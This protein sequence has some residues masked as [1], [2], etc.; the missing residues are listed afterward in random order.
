MK[1]ELLDDLN[2]APKPK[3]TKPNKKVMIVG[4]LMSFNLFA[5]QI[6]TER[7]S[8]TELVLGSYFWMPFLALGLFGGIYPPKKAILLSVL[9]VPIIFIFYGVIWPSL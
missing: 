2:L 9:T 1:N 3:K 8:E 4:F 5:Y 6:L 7:T